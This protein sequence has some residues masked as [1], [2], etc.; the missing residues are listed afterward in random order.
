MKV[1]RPSGGS[2]QSTGVGK[3]FVKYDNAD[4]ARTALQALAGRKFADRTVVTTYFSE[5]RSRLPIL[6]L[7]SSL[8]NCWLTMYVAGKF[9]GRRLVD[10][11]IAFFTFPFRYQNQ[12]SRLCHPYLSLFYFIHPYP[13]DLRAYAPQ[14]NEQPVFHSVVSPSF[15][16][17]HPK[18][19][20]PPLCL[21]PLHAFLF[22]AKGG[23]WKE[24][25]KDFNSSLDKKNWLVCC[26]FLP[27]FHFLQT[28]S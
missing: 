17:S 13:R 25:W 10:G 4:S 22:C 21:S 18:K 8:V 20:F 1:P 3:I 5:V 12:N 6:D 27:I 9:R 16:F 28:P 15:C 2:R 14:N 26:C 11:A 7:A 24:R 19:R 23:E